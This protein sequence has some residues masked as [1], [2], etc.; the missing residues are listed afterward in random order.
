MMKP[1]AETKEFEVV[2][3]HAGVT[4]ESVRAQTG[5]SVRFSANVDETRP[6]DRHELD[7]LRD[8]NARTALAHAT[9]TR[10]SRRLEDRA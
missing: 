10:V 3:L 2:S 6:P 1:D 9:R 7:A 4:R 8:L 5:W